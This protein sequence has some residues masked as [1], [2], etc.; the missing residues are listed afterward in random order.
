MEK[1][2]Q[3]PDVDADRAGKVIVFAGP[4]VKRNVV[5]PKLEDAVKSTVVPDTF[6]VTY[7][8]EV[9]AWIARGAVVLDPYSDPLRMVNPLTA[10]LESDTPPNPNCAV[11]VRILLYPSANRIV[12]AVDVRASCT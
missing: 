6:D 10:P 4:A 8:Y 5:A 12:P 2:H 1:L 3:V 11:R 7:L 9:G